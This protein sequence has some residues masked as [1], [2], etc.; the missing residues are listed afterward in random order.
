MR[1]SRVRYKLAWIKNS[2]IDLAHLDK[3][4]FD[5]IASFSKMFRPGTVTMPFEPGA[6]QD[7]IHRILENLADVREYLTDAE[8]L[9]KFD[10]DGLRELDTVTHFFM[11]HLK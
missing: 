8:G 4:L 9:N 2:A 3:Y 6:C 11:A 10:V 1:K 7:E 5:R